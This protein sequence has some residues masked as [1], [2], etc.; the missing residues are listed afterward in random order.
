MGSWLRLAV[1]GPRV[2]R[3]AAGR[4]WTAVS[5]EFD[6]VD[7]A[8]SRF[9][10]DSEISRLN[11][12][13]G[14]ADPLVVDRRLYAG[15]AAAHRAWR[16]TEG[17]FEP[18]ILITMDELGY[19]GAPVEFRPS[20]DRW[21]SEWLWRCPRS[22]QV[23]IAEPLDLGGIGKGLAL[24][25]A[26]RALWPEL[27]HAGQ[28]GVLLDAGGDLVVGGPAPDGDAWRI[29]VEDPSGGDRPIA[30][31]AVGCGAVCTSSTMVNR[32]VDER[33]EA[34]HHLIDPATHRPAASGLLSVTVAGR[35]AAWAEV[36]SKALFI[37]GVDG[38]AELARRHGLAAWWVREPV[39]LEM[40]P[41]A[42]LLTV[43]TA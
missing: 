25:W 19:R 41:A 35:D 33:G 6:A 13:A 43:W 11:A 34:I 38:I 7:R 37:A 15:L 8:M 28:V 18:R 36:W 22:R 32:W 5:A 16:M 10:A 42:R 40:T 20:A 1:H 3:G 27:P 21:A 39:T 14:S 4:G 26:W 17:R 29:G 23:R 24:R 2:P 30:V 31:V 9:Q 12:R